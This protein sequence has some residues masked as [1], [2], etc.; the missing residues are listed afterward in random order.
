MSFTYSKRKY[1]LLEGTE[2][3]HFFLKNMFIINNVIN[4]V[5]HQRFLASIFFKT[6]LNKINYFLKIYIQPKYMAKFSI[7]N[8]FTRSNYL[9]IMYAFTICSNFC[10]SKW[11]IRQIFHQTHKRAF[12]GR[13]NWLSGTSWDFIQTDVMHF[14]V[15]IIKNIFYYCSVTF[16]FLGSLHRLMKLNSYDW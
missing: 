12:L 7:K 6:R 14:M 5:I 8:W 16:L 9:H 10:T 3:R 1:E 13:E 4:C 2:I 11:K 15:W